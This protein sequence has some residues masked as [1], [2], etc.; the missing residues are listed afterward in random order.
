MNKSTSTDWPDPTDW[1]KRLYAKLEQIGEHYQA[2]P[3]IVAD[4]PHSFEGLNQKQAHAADALLATCRALNE[5]PLF[6]KSKGA[7][8]LHSIAGAFHDVVMGGSPRLFMS[9]RPGGPGGDGIDRNYVKFHVVL[10]ARFLVEAYQFTDNK[11]ASTVA[12][13]FSDAGAT[14]RKGKPLSSS[15]V[16]DWCA[17]VH[18]LASNVEEARLH[19][20]VE[21]KLEEFRNDPMWPGSWTDALAWISRMASDPLLTSKYG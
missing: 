12:K 21:A 9:V 8:V 16:K 5:L 15:T 18:Q 17:K 19:H 1:A 11:A 4:D 13:I 2:T 20:A 14:G 10:A 3:W 6:E 7:A